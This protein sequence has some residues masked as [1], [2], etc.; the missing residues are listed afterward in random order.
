M[1]QKLSILLLF[2]LITSISFAQQTITGIVTAVD[3]QPL[4]GV[5]I[6]LKGTTTGTTTDFDGNFSIEAPSNGVLIFSYIGFLTQEA[7]INNQT[8]LSITLKEDISRL[9]EVIVVGYGTQKKSDITGAVTS[10]KVG[11]LTS[12][13]L[14]RTDEVLQGQVAGVQINNNDASPNASS[15]IR[16]RGVSSIN[17]GSNPLIIIDG[18][19]GASLSDVHP[20]DIKSIEVLKDASAT[21]IYG[22]RGAAGVILIT[23]KKGRLEKPTLTYNGYTTLHSIR[24]K[25]DFMNGSQYAQYINRNRVV[26]GIAEVFSPTQLSDI[27]ASGGTDWQDEIFRSGITQNHHLTIGGGTEDLDYNISGDFLDTKGIIIGSNYKKF[28][29]RTNIGLKLSEKLKVKV[30][31]FANFAKDNPTVLDTRDAFGSPVYAALLF[32]PTKPIFEADGSYSQPGG[33]FGPTTEYNPVALALEP[34]RNNYSNTILFNPKVEY[35]ILDVLTAS[36]GASY[37]LNDSENNFYYN[38]KVIAGSDTDRQASISDSK[39]SR[40]QNTNILTYEDV[41][42]EKHNLKITGVFEQ[43]TTKFNS[44]FSSGNGFFSN[45]NLYDALENSANPTK[46]S[47][48][49]EKSDLESYMGRLN[50]AYNN[51][52]SLTLTWRADRTSVFQNNQW[53]YFPSAGIAWNI[54]NERFLE[55][56]KVINNLKLRGSYGEVGNQGVGPYQ[57]LDQLRT[58]SNVSFGGGTLTTGLSLSTQLGNPDLKWETTE[59]MNIGVDLGMFNGRLSLTADYYKKNTTDLLLERNVLAASG[60]LTQLVNAGEVENKGFEIALSGKPIVIG[61]FEW[62]TNVT[63]TKNE[64][65]VVA[66]NDGKTELSVGGAGTPGFSDAIWLEVGQPIGL[67]RGY[68]FDGIWKSDEAILAAAYGVTPGSPKYVDQ[69]NDGIINSDDIVN[70]AKALPDY[71]FGWNNTFK[72]RGLSL[73]VFVIG[74]QGNDILN[75]G[76]YLTERNDGLSTALLNRWTPTNE[77]TNIPGHNQVGT[78]RNSSRWVEDGSYIRIKNITL[79]YNLPSK[80]TESLSISSAKIYFTGSNLFTFTDYLGYDPESNNATSLLSDSSGNAS[81]YAGIDTASYP[82]Q[83]KFTIGLD[84]KF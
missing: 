82:S 35:N 56:S 75:I 13:P 62:D 5:T 43:Q 30:N 64:N 71:T 34:I 6:L 14:A 50:Y 81:T 17:G 70:I 28:S 29:G 11:E 3:N 22:S 15:T 19:Q 40:Y 73:N 32:S 39:W 77:N 25:L 69:N 23:T 78:R 80:V 10:V 37:Q 2:L 60:S 27:A 68:K 44:N 66:L 79:G 9:D 8:K 52:Y 48:Y 67:I 84:I 54:S 58:G 42:N 53:G 41:F 21:A 4:P 74:V 45:A 1:K 33:G 18:T 63:F 38:E 57:T 20:N 51:L 36:V 83:K 76:R 7:A 72:Y 46:P 59:Q 31:M 49:A 26:R 12:I 16:I 47:S 55:N 24:E 61:D 65:E